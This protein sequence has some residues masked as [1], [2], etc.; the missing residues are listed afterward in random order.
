MSLGRALSL[1]GKL[2]A[3]TGVTTAAAGIPL[4]LNF[5]G[6]V[7]QDAESVLTKDGSTYDP[8]TK[9]VK[10][11]AGEVLFD[12]L[13]NR[14]QA[15]LEAGKANRVEKLKDKFSELLTA[16]PDT[17]ITADSNI[18]QLRNLQK[19]VKDIESAIGVAQ[20]VG[21]PKT[22]SELE[23]IGDA[24]A[25]I[26]MAEDYKKKTALEDAQELSRAEFYSKPA[27]YERE[28]KAAKDLLAQQLQMFQFED[29]R[30]E[31]RMA[32]RKQDL[33][34]QQTRL[35]NSRADRKDQQV[36]LMTLIQGLAQM[37]NSVV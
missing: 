15:I 4:A 34:E 14:E 26:R 25:I 2:L 19:N 29:A 11:K 35:Q 32:N 17:K 23:N 5:P 10:R 27:V 20:S 33:V 8:T 30:A 22:R 12:K 3:G 13:F 36:A 37:G 21:L 24:G 7:G 9:K 16:R 31:R 18:N 28:Q 1:G 6:L